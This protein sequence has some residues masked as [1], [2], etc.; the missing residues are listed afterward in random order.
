[1]DLISSQGV[2]LFKHVKVAFLGIIHLVVDIL[3]RIYVEHEGKRSL[4]RG[5][6]NRSL[7]TAPYS[8]NFSGVH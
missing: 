3:R 8:S 2:T 4:G 7:R 5:P 6:L 1:V